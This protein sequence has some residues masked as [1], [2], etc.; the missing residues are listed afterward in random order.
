MDRVRVGVRVL[1]EQAFDVYT[2]SH[3]PHG[4]KREKRAMYLSAN[5]VV[6][7]P[8]VA[9]VADVPL[10]H[11]VVQQGVDLGAVRGDRAGLG[12]RPWRCRARGV[13]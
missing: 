4:M 8:T 5:V 12:P 7:D 3:P 6:G 11:E 10:G 1:L 2:A 9:A 13:R